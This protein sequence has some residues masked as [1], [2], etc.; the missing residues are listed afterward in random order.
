VLPEA[1]VLVKRLR[2]AAASGAAPPGPPTYFGNAAYRTRF[3]QPFAAFPE[4]GATPS[5]RPACSPG[6]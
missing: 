2:V 1:N 4:V 3:D 5:P 6:A